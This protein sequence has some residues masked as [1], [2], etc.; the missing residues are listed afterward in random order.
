MSDLVGQDGELVVNALSNWQPVKLFQEEWP[1]WRLSRCPQNDS[2]R[3]D[4]RAR[5]LISHIMPMRI[6]A[7]TISI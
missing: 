1:R 6:T 7:I 5:Y 4:S 3:A 2:C